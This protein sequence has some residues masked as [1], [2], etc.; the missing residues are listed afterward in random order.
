MLGQVMHFSKR[1]GNN[2]SVELG[3]TRKTATRSPSEKENWG[4]WKKNLEDLRVQ[5]TAAVMMCV[6]VEKV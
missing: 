5:D 2:I 4:V 1:Y 6:T 3:V